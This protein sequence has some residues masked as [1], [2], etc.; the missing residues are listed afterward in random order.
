MEIKVHQ[1]AFGEKVAMSSKFFTSQDY[2][3]WMAKMKNF[4][5]LKGEKEMMMILQR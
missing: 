2:S 1:F 5:V 4:E 3:T